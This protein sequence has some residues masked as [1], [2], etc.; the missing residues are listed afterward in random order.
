MS[1]SKN[2][3]S[4]HSLAILAIDAVICLHSLACSSVNPSQASSEIMP[5]MTKLSPAKVKAASNSSVLLMKFVLAATFADSIARRSFPVGGA[6]LTTC[7]LLREEDD[8]F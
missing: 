7:K 4:G 2:V 5:N 6:A 3:T 8:R 1:H